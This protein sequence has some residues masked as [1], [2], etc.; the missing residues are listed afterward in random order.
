M[1]SDIAFL[2]S[3]A[4]HLEVSFK[5]LPID[6]VVL[7][8]SRSTLNSFVENN[9]LFYCKKHVKLRIQPASELHFSF[10]GIQ[11]TQF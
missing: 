1:G 9:Y 5:S 3:S 10:D 2:S 11:A 4:K 7:L 6:R 8:T